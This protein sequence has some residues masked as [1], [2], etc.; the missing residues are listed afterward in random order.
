MITPNPTTEEIFTP[1]ELAAADARDLVFLLG[2]KAWNDFFI[3][4]MM[5]LQHR[6]LTELADPSKK[7]RDEKPDDYLRGYIRAVRAIMNA[8]GEILYQQ[9]QRNRENA[10]N[11]SVAQRYAEIAHGGRSPY[12]EERAAISPTDPI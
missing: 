8:P 6:A 2:S 5:G 3:P 12:G 11:D 9:E 1:D 7:R 4:L 10:T